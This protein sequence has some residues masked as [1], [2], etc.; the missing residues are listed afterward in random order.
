MKTV[1]NLNQSNIYTEVRCSSIT[2]SKIKSFCFEYGTISDLIALR[3]FREK[4]YQNK[5]KTRRHANDFIL[6][7]S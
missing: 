3:I 6:S 4:Y 5:G 1:S 7:A 2:E